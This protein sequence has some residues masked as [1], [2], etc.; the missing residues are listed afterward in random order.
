[1]K[2]ICL[3]AE[4][5]KRL[6][7]IEI[8]PDGNIVQIVGKNG[9][10]KSSVLDSLWWALAGAKHI[11]SVPIREGEDRAH[12][13][14]DLG[15]I[16]VTRTF[17]TS[18]KGE[19]TSGI[20]VEN[21]EGAKFGSP[22]KML[23]ELL[24]ELTFDPLAFS[25]MDAKEQFNTLR[26]FV[27][28]VDF[29]QIEEDNKTDYGKRTDINRRAKEARTL[30]DE[31]EV[32]AGLPDERVDDSRL[33]DKMEEAGNHNANIETR[34]ANREARQNRANQKKDEGVRLH[35]RSS[36]LREEAKRVDEDASLALEEAAIIER[37]IDQA[38]PLP[39]PIDI[40][41]LRETIR[42]AGLVNKQI[43]ER[44]RKKKLLQ[45]SKELEAKS[46][47]LTSMM[48]QRE[49]GKRVAIA[50]VKLPVEGISFGYG[51]IL[52][53]DVP[54]EQA[55]D[56]EQLRASVAMAMAMN[57]KL[58][59]I[60][61]RDGSLLDEDSMNMISE[62]ADGNDFQIWIERVD[63]SGKF[64]FVL[65]DGHLKDKDKKEEPEL[66]P[67]AAFIRSQNKKV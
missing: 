63:S 29:D 51:E 46:N 42:N 14:L 40:S 21:A 9:A 7:A 45:E 3:Q 33:V 58:R 52:L 34:K 49:Q 5:I 35:E 26:K 55:S 18:K 24:G 16:I 57:P 10:G 20:S 64:G 47:A 13:R 48:E 8:K 2:I 44:E 28:D 22:Q 66:E 53:N 12:I 11:Q 36:K 61:V 37:E 19:V 30:A 60:R 25:R 27:P 59:V 32:P 50:A 67:A 4:N 6:V 1:M 54:F 17:K 39:K 23:D 31:I 56:A 65:E 43:E 62:M 15:E 38:E 41:E